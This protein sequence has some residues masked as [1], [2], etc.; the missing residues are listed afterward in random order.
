MTIQNKNER[1]AKE[2]NELKSIISQK[3][4]MQERIMESSIKAEYKS[5]LSYKQMIKTVDD[6]IDIIETVL[7]QCKRIRESIIKNRGIL[8]DS[9]NSNRAVEDKEVDKFK[10]NEKVGKNNK[11]RSNLFLELNNDILKEENK[12]NENRKILEEELFN[13]WGNK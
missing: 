5:I 2:N 9:T 7:D 6:S 13:S 12:N 8:S 4:Q 3:I 1:L 10:E 11:K